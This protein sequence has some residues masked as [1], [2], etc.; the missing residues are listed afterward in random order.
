MFKKY[1]GFTIFVSGLAFNLIESL[2]F[3]IGTV[4]GFNITP[5]NT[6]ELICDYISL[7][8]IILGVFIMAK[9]IDKN[10]K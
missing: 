5:I 7:A 3:G 8:I 10:V 6:G 2:Y 1:K 4:R 9:E